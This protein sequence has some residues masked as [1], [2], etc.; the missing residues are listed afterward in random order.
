MLV[1][2]QISLGSLLK[3]KNRYEHFTDF[4]KLIYRV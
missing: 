4:S 3:K 1:A 2:S